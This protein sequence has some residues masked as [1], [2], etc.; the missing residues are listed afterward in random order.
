MASRMAARSTT[1]GTPVKSC[2]TTR[3]GRKGTSA[4]EPE[5]GVQPARALHVLLG[6]E[7]AAAV[8]QHGLQEHLDRVRRAGQ[9]LTHGVEPVDDVGSPARLEGVTGGEDIGRPGQSRLLLGCAMRPESLPFR[10]T[11]DAIGSRSSTIEAERDLVTITR[12]CRR[13][14]R[15]GRFRSSWCR[16]RSG[17]GSVASCRAR[18]R[19]TGHARG[20]WTLQAAHHARP[21]AYAAR[22]A[23]RRADEGRCA[24]RRRG[25]AAE[26]SARARAPSSSRASMGSIAGR[27]GVAR[28]RSGRRTPSR[29]GSRSPGPQ[30]FRPPR[31]RPETRSDRRVHGRSPGVHASRRGRDRARTEMTHRMRGTPRRPRADGDGPERLDDERPQFGENG[32]DRFARTGAR[33]DPLALDEPGPAEPLDASRWPL[34]T[35]RSTDRAVRERPA[36]VGRRDHQRASSAGLTGERQ[37]RSE[38]RR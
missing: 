35:A 22:S 9:V 37:I 13:S 34:E 28:T 17:S 19:R 24:P 5:R 7:A 15:P 2:I 16:T 30:E 31:R 6:D 18:R 4:V 29:R 10:R 27:R 23:S 3:A 32:D 38:L 8:A 1:Q 11:S 26:M 20:A 36:P 21:G 25:D 14:C 33:P 12:A